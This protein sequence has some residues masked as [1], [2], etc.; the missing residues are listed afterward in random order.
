MSSHP[1]V[2]SDLLNRATHAAEGLGAFA[3]S[4]GA[5]R[6]PDLGQRAQALAAELRARSETVRTVRPRLGFVAEKGVGKSTLVTSLANLWL[7]GHPPDADAS[8]RR[9]IGQALLPLGNGGTTPCEVVVE[10]GPWEIVVEPAPV[11]DAA[12]HVEQYAAWA[13]H[14]AR[15]AD[16]EDDDRGGPPKPEDDIAW[17]LRGLTR[18]G[19]LLKGGEDPEVDPAVHAAKGFATPAAFVE[20]L[21][22]GAAL[23]ARRKTHWLPPHGLGEGAEAPRAW[24]RDALRELFAGREAEQPFPRR[25]T[26]RAPFEPIRWRDRAVPYVDTLGLPAVARKGDEPG[27][28]IPQPLAARGD[29]RALL[30]D[31]WTVAVIGSGF[32]DPPSPSVPLLQQMAEERPW[33]GEALEDRTVVVIVDPG[34]AGANTRGMSPEQERAH[35]LERCVE[36]LRTMGL[37]EAEGGSGQRRWSAAQLRERIACVNVLEQGDAPLSDF[38]RK[39]FER[40]EAGHRRRLEAAVLAAERF[41]GTLEDEQRLALNRQVLEAFGRTIQVLAEDIGR[42]LAQRLQSPLGPFAK[43][44]QSR[45]PSSIYS[46]TLHAGEG[47]LNAWALLESSLSRDLDRLL[48]PAREAVVRRMTELKRDPAFASAL[49][50]VEDEGERRLTAIDAQLRRVVEACAATIGAGMA[51][52][53]ALW[54]RAK[55]EYGQGPGYRDRVAAHFR[56]WGQAHA[57]DLQVAIGHHLQAAESPADPD[58]GALL[59]L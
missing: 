6:F 2:P 11:A 40:V 19:S 14:R 3:R 28:G 36:N 31:P 46:M 35:K 44:L 57:S 12:R 13:W 39:A 47:T 22:A 45:H 48:Q 4:A 33:F 58:A 27:R 38:L 41:L 55:A 53:G 1:I 9:I 15:A 25:L 51:A 30:K 42:R 21:L 50:M 16:G 23:G 37:P 24:L 8:A 59:A 54:K 7:A 26:V 56:R 32:T 5:Q 43:A 34:K 49:A 52:D 18:V 17:L 10:A 29:L 20:G